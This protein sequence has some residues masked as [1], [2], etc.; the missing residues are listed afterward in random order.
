M[1][2]AN[3]TRRSVMAG[4]AA[5][6]AAIPTLAICA[7]DAAAR[8]EH[9]TRELEQAMRDLYG[10]EVQMLRFEP[11]EGMTAC[12]MVAAN[13]GATARPRANSKWLYVGQE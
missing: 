11:T 2:A 13:G 8:V 10:R 5:V 6:V 9:H 3:L 12:V 1:T 7:S 4:S